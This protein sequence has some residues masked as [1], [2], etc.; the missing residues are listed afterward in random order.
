MSARLLGWYDAHARELPWRTAASAS[1]P[2]SDAYAVWVSEVM[3]QQTRVETVK[4]YYARFLARFPTVLA[5]AEAPLD[6]VLGAWSGL[7]YYRRAR[8]LHAAAREVAARHGGVMP[9]TY[10]TLGELPGVGA[11]TAGAIASIAFG[12]RVPAVDGNV[13]RVLSR[14]YA[15]DEPLGSTKSVAR[16]RPLAEALV[17]AS[18][19]GDHNQALMELGAT[20][21]IPRA[22]RCEVCPLADACE[23]RRAGRENELPVVKKKAP[24]PVVKMTAALAREPGAKKSSFALGRRP[25]EGLFGGLWEPPMIEGRGKAAE[26]TLRSAGLEAGKRLGVVRHVLTHRVL[27]VAVVEATASRSLST[28]PPYEELAWGRPGPERGLST[29]AKRILELAT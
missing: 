9:R 26:K 22:P 19:P 2:T 4:S 1:P 13:N 6:D 21:C 10:T 24:S 25:P 15:C 20:V 27:E 23:A 8:A 11:Y 7:G 29:L 5:L 18:R 17:S 14:L 28:I 12:E 16:L 3:L